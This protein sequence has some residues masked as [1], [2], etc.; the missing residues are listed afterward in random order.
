MA[1]KREIILKLRELLQAGELDADPE[2]KSKVQQAIRSWVAVNPQD[3][4]AGLETTQ[5]MQGQGAPGTQA[6]APKAENIQALEAAQPQL[7]EQRKAE[8]AALG[9]EKPQQSRFAPQDYP[10][11]FQQLAAQEG[12]ARP[13]MPTPA[14]HARE[15]E[16]LAAFETESQLRDK[17][18]ELTDPS[19][20]SASKTKPFYRPPELPAAPTP[21]AGP[22]ET[23]LQGM[24]KANAP[25][26]Y[27]EPSLSQFHDEMQYEIPGVRNLGEESTAFKV[28][29]DSRYANAF[30]QAKAMG[31]GI[32][33]IS[34]ARDTGWKER[35]GSI[36]GSAVPAGL[37][38]ATLGGS[39][40]LT[41]TLGGKKAEQEATLRE[42]SGPEAAGTV[43]GIAGM[44]T[45]LPTKTFEAIGGLAGKAVPKSLAT[46][47]LGRLGVSALKGA[48]GGAGL[49]TAET[50]SRNTAHAIA[51]K[52]AGELVP[53][54]EDLQHIATAGA[55]GMPLGLGGEL[56]GMGAGAA[57]RGLRGGKL[58]RE[59]KDLEA[60]G[61]R[62]TLLGIKPSPKVRELERASAASPEG[63]T[64]VE[65]AGRELEEPLLRSVGQAQV[66]ENAA[67]KRVKDKA[68]EY[69]GSKTAVPWNAIEEGLRQ[70][71]ALRFSSDGKLLPGA[72]ERG[73]DLDRIMV[74]EP[75]LMDYMDAEEFLL[76]NP[77]AKTYTAQG[78]REA[79][80]NIGKMRDDQVLVLQGKSMGL[81][82]ARNALD[83]FTRKAGI[84]AGTAEGHLQ[85]PEAKGMRRALRDFI[86]TEFPHLDLAIEG[87]ERTLAARRLEREGLALP[88]ELT[89]SKSA[90]AEGG[91]YVLPEDVRVTLEGPERT[92]FQQ[93]MRSPSKTLEQ[94]EAETYAARRGQLEPLLGTLREALAVSKLRGATQIRE[95]L[96]VSPGGARLFG[97]GSLG[98]LPYKFD[99]VLKAMERMPEE[100]SA[101][102]VDTVKQASVKMPPELLR[103][104]QRSE[105]NIEK[106]AAGGRKKM[107]RFYTE[108]ELQN[109][110]DAGISK[111]VVHIMRSESA[112][113][114][115]IRNALGDAARAVASEIKVRKA[116]R[117]AE[118]TPVLNTGR[119]PAPGSIRGGRLGRFGAAGQTKP[120]DLSPEEMSLLMLLLETMP[121]EKAEKPKEV[122]AK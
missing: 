116:L 38:T 96:S 10:P 5:A 46:G 54:Q 26:Y 23:P 49:A 29:A 118:P 103:A 8:E 22:N 67:M 30:D 77:T 89:V 20:P 86:D 88:D 70:Q 95:G 111:T 115:E 64:P 80:I 28:W 75:K 15:Q 43:G 6:A 85:K 122:A 45:P 63:A 52:D 25:I 31:M 71:K 100:Q 18:G 117:E 14:E 57:R 112:T 47:S 1:D 7:V 27:T 107:P 109:M 83:I 33:R 98:R 78:A 37:R 32:V 114:K 87:G 40:L 90:E 65:L 2:R 108:Q 79:G 91:K 51:S 60:G 34:H 35:I 59:L 101:K 11:Q 44:L 55:I 74:G 36:A 119:L 73:E 121:E 41:S 76:N 99:N 39:D 48:A 120:S 9:E 17:F 92:A 13:G 94:R 16:R 42:E 97:T 104:V 82:D 68:S 105:A 62:S 102:L 21:A 113:G 81:D 69:E 12:A 72:V 56:G 84:P 110:E 3:A 106:F 50:M 66:N 19:L 61:G 4:Q 53:D 24:A 58:G 93:R